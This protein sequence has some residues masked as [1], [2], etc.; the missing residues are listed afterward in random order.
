MDNLFS[1][2][3]VFT[4][5]RVGSTTL[6]GSEVDLLLIKVNAFQSLAH[7]LRNSILGPDGRLN[8]PLCNIIILLVRI[9]L[10]VFI[11]ITL[12]TYL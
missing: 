11:Q 6:T 3:I 1:L 10:P 7:V 9:Q 12:L 8:Q 2:Y 5:I 4:I